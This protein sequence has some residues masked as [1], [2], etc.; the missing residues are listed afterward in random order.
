MFLEYLL[1]RADRHLQPVLC[2]R[3]RAGPAFVIGAVRI[4][5]IVEIYQKPATAQCL[6]LQITAS[7]V[8]FCSDQRI[9]EGQEKLM[10]GTVNRQLRCL[11]I[12]RKAE[13]T[14]AHIILH[15]AG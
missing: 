14:E 4:V 3:Y 9:S 11:P 7:R 15:V 13:S 10:T 2:R 6:R 8:G 12:N 5:G 1:P